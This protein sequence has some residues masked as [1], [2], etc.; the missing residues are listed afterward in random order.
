MWQTMGCVCVCVC[1][2]AGRHG[3]VIRPLL[4]TSLQH[5]TAR[6]LHSCLSLC[7]SMLYPP[8]L[9]TGMQPQAPGQPP[10]R[11]KPAPPMHMQMFELLCLGTQLPQLSDLLPGPDTWLGELPC[12]SDMTEA[13]AMQA[14]VAQTFLDVMFGAISRGGA[15]A[16]GPGLA[17]HGTG[18]VAVTQDGLSTPGAMGRAGAAATQRQGMAGAVVGGSEEA[19]WRVLHWFFA[20]PVHGAVMRALPGVPAPTHRTE[21]DALTTVR[22][23]RVLFQDPRL[24]TDNALAR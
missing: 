15:E 12:S 21:L 23:V 20:G 16:A 17:A 8:A 5:S 6:H 22:F 18:G 11:L 1:V 24:R 13:E 19:A 3:S 2:C 10:S 4:I 14:W 7:L 9:F